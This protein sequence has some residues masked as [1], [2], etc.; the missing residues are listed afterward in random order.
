MEKC[1]VEWH[2]EYIHYKVVQS[3]ERDSKT[4]QPNFRILQKITGE[5]W[6]EFK[7]L[8]Y[9]VGYGLLSIK[10][11]DPGNDWLVR[12]ALHNYLDSL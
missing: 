10:N 1:I 4:G 5:Q 2:D 12:N 3:E 9:V 8:P 6:E 11:N 7:S